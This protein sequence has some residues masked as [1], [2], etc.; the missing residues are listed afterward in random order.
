MLDRD[1][2]F[3][4]FSVSDTEC[5]KIWCC[6]CFNEQEDEVEREGGNRL[7]LIKG[8]DIFG[9]D[10]L[11]DN[12]IGNDEQSVVCSAAP[13]GLALP[14]RERD[15]QFRLFEEMVRAVRVG[16]FASWSNT[17]LSEGESSSAAAVVA[18]GGLESGAEDSRDFHHKRAKVHS[19]FE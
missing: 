7:N 14:G 18:A 3:L 13:L 5:M 11:N 8:E 6:L 2:G 4:N 17:P 10:G 1:L 19:D 15:E 9:N 16:A 12:D